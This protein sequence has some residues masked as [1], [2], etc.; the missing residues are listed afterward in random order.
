MVGAYMPLQRLMLAEGLIT[1]GIFCASEP[2]MAF[3]RS[4]VAP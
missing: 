3:M 2:F 1:W 4:L